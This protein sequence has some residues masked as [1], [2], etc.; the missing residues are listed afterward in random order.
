MADNKL[1]GH[2][3]Y[4]WKCK[5]L[6]WLPSSLETVARANANI[7]FY[8]PHGHSAHYAEG[9]SNEAK[10]R[11]ERDRL[12]QQVAQRDDEI[13]RQRELREAAERQAAAARGQ[14]TK[15][16]RRAAGGV[17][18]HCNRT[19]SQLARHMHSKHKEILCQSVN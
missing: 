1:N 7:S 3:G 6:M 19:F 2:F 14:V 4:C 18:A 10:L 16:K 5:T 13:K 9:E 8:C 17:C 11:R 15:L 12:A